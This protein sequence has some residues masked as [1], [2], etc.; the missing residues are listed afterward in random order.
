M[1]KMFWYHQNTGNSHKTKLWSNLK[2]RK[3]VNILARVF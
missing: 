1:K 3:L 2:K